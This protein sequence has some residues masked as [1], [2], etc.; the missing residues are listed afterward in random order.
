MSKNIP[1]QPE[2]KALYKVLTSHHMYDANS[3]F[4][5]FLRH[6][7][8]KID[9]N[10]E[11][12]INK[13][14]KYMD[15]LDEVGSLYES[16]VKSAEPLTDILGVVHQ[17]LVSRGSSSALGQFFTPDAV[18]ALIAEIMMPKNEEVLKSLSFG[19]DEYYSVQEPS[20]GFGSMMF[21]YIKRCYE[22]DPRIVSRLAIYAIDIDYACCRGFSIQMFMNFLHH[23]V[24]V[25][26][27]NVING[28]TLGPLEDLVPYFGWTVKDRSGA[29]DVNLSASEMILPV[30]A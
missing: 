18:S 2:A 13:D 14:E 10:L 3:I 9:P 23:G 16:L 25:G 8:S 4:H 27:L 1:T 20:V 12:V 26:Q 11:G 22:L 30:A 7:M 17:S 19:D 21:R 15:L 28:N 24:E 6:T 5:D 29:D